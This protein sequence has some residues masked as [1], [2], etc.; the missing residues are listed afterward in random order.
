MNEVPQIG[1]FLVIDDN[2]IIQRTVYFALRDAGFQVLM[3][4]DVST[5]TK[6]LRKEKFDL[7]LVDLSFPLDVSDIG[8]PQ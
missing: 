5:A 8:G 7:V 2:P 4:G 1:K 6:M 3:V